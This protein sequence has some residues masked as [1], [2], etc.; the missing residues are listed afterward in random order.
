MASKLR[1][2]LFQRKALKSL[3]EEEGTLNLFLLPF[4]LRSTKL[5]RTPLSIQNFFFLIGG[6]SHPSPVHKKIQPR[7]WPFLKA[8]PRKSIGEKV[9]CVRAGT[10]IYFYVQRRCGAGSSSPAKSDRL[11]QTQCIEGKKFQTNFTRAHTH[12]THALYTFS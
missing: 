2:R 5:L 3:G 4:R 8:M 7:I 11:G 9:M 12:D 10:G 6:A 1:N